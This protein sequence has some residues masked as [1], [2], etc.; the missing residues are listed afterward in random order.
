MARCVY[1][2]ADVVLLDDCLSAVDAHV[3]R[4]LFDNCIID[5]L[6]QKQKKGSNTKR[7]V[8][9]VT[10]ALQYLSHSKVDRIVVMKDGRIAESGTYQDLERRRD[11]E[12]KKYLSAFGDSMS[13]DDGHFHRF[14]ELGVAVNE[15]DEAENLLIPQSLSEIKNS[16]RVS[17]RLS[18][19]EKASATLMTDEMAEREV[20]KVGGEVYAIWAKAAGGLWV[21]VPLLLIFAAGESV[22]ILSNWWLTYWSHAASPDPESQLYFLGI[23]GFINIIAIFVDF[24]RMFAVLYLGLRASKNVSFR[25]TIEM[26]I[27][28]LSSSKRGISPCFQLFSSLLDS[29][30]MA[31]MSFFETTPAGRIMNRFSKGMSRSL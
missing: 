5:V 6:L 20:G 22:K 2:D 19:V 13:K 26:V 4:E 8:V 29:T 24:C 17:Q 14:T 1:R 30:L 12:F 18:D 3:G 15:N 28:P 7:T 9:L 31:P 10:N 16:T 25:T 23:Y 27:S 21:V 11:S